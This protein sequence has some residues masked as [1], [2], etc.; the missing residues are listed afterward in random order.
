MNRDENLELLQLLEE[1]ARRKRYN[2]LLHYKPYAKQVEFHNL[3]SKYKQR[4]LGAGNQ[5]GKTVS[6]SM[7]AAYHATGLY[8][9]N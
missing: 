4:C 2:K 3:S 8:P 9:E 1:K 5:L 7:E 6:G